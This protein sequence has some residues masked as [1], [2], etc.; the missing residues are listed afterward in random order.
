MAHE[1]L[2]DLAQAGVFTAVEARDGRRGEILRS[3]RDAR[4]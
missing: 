1:T 4:Y 3:G 2:H